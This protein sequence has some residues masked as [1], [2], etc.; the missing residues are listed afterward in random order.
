LLNL[1]AK[2]N[3]SI[4]TSLRIFYKISINCKYRQNKENIRP[5]TIY[6]KILSFKNTK[7]KKKF[8]AN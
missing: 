7:V 8:D 1:I 2:N 6:S 4:T 3:H 5:N